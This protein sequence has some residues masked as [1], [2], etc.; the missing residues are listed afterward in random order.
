MRIRRNLTV[1]SHDRTLKDAGAVATSNWSAGSRWKGCGSCVDSTTIRGWRCRNDT[2]GSAR[3][4]SIQSPTERSSFSLPYS[5]SFATSQQE[6]ILTA[7]TRSAPSSRSSRC[8]GC[9]RS[10]RETHQT[11]MWV[12]SRITVG[13][14]SPRW[15]QAPT[16]HGTREPNLV[17]F[18]PRPSLIPRFSRAATLPPAGRAQMEGPP[19]QVRH[20]HR[21]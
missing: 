18:G 16:A 5:T 2:P 11:Q 20:A 19:K 8:L 10:G 12:S 9:S 14:P 17:G 15:Q 13:R 3:A 21:L 4:V 7:Q 1:L 6:L